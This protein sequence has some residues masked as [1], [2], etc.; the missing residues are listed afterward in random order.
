MKGTTTTT[1]ATNFTHVLKEIYCTPIGAAMIDDICILIAEYASNT[2]IR[3]LA[4][5]VAS[6]SIFE[7]V[8][9][10]S[11]ETSDGPWALFTITKGICGNNT[12]AYSADATS[13]SWTGKV[14]SATMTLY[15]ISELYDA[16]ATSAITA[17]YAQTYGVRA[18]ALFDG[19]LTFESCIRR[20]IMAPAFDETQI[21]FND[22]VLI[23]RSLWEFV[24][25]VVIA[26]TRVRLISIH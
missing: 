7:P 8:F 14:V 25:R 2:P 12:V 9:S 11:I 10:Q 21:P 24:K 15:S 26:S 18:S 4:D 13:K 1:T 19:K 6:T 22:D 17:K 3:T 16:I 20:R 5:I 23:R